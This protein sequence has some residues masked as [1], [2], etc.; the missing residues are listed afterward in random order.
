M[1]TESI[2]SYF[3]L[4]DESQAQA[5]FIDPVEISSSWSVQDQKSGYPKSIRSERLGSVLPEPH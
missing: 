4:P 2:V 3:E 1:Q 5:E